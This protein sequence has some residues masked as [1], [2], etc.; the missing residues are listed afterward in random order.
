MLSTRHSGLLCEILFA[1]CRRV[2]LCVR[3][4]LNVR[5]SVSFSHC[6]A[7]RSKAPKSRA[8]KSRTPIVIDESPF[9]NYV[10][11]LLSGSMFQYLISELKAAVS[12]YSTSHNWKAI[13]ACLFSLNAVGECV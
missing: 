7:S 11:T 6:K 2:C 3:V 1:V 4:Y 13:E 8:P 12:A 5:G 10:Y 9:Q